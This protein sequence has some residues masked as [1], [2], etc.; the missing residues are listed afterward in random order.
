MKSVIVITTTDANETTPFLK[1]LC[2]PDF[3]IL[4]VVTQN[5]MIFLAND[6]EL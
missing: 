4:F 5:M 6:S 1:K 3:V 2:K